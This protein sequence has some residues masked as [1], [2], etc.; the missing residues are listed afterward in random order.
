[1]G[2]PILVIAGAG[3]GKTRTLVHR[4]AFLVEQGVP[5]SQILLLTFTRKASAEMLSRARQLHP[6]C[7]AVEGGTFHSL[8]HRLLRQFGRRLE[9]P[10]NFTVIDRVDS[11]QVIRGVVEEL[12]LKDKGDKHFP[13]PRALADIISRSRNLELS[14]EE[15]IE[16]YAPQHEP[17]SAQVMGIAK[18]FKESK[19]RQ[20]L[21]DY[22]DLLFMGEELLQG[23]VEVRRELSRR[24]RHLLVDEYQD[25]NAVQARLVALLAS[26]HKNVMVVGDDAQS[27]YA[28]R[29]ARLQNILEF[30]HKFPG[31]RLVKLERN[32]RSS[33]PILDL[34]NRIIAQARERFDK[35][36]YTEQSGGL[37]PRLLRLRDERAQSR[38]VLKGI[39][40]L[41]AQGAAPE[42]IA[43][44]FRAGN[45][46]ADLE[47]E[48]TAEGLAH[49]KVGGL[50]FL[51]ASHIKDVLSHLRVIANPQDFLSW[52]R[53]LMLLPGLGPKKAQQIMAQL[54]LESPPPGYAVGLKYLPQVAQVPELT[55]LA[56]LLEHL[57]QP[58]LSPL[59]ATEAVLEYFEPICRQNYEDY[60]RRLRDLEELPGLA[61]NY[62]NLEELMAEVVLEPPANRS[63]E[64]GAG[65]LTLST[66]H[67]AK[68]LEWDHVFVL[69]LSEGR[70]PAGPTL[71]DPQALEEERRLLYVACTRA[72]Q[73]LTLLAPREY[74]SRGQGLTPVQLCRFLED[75]EPG[76]L[77]TPRLG[78]VFDVAPPA[79]APA[80]P[81]SRGSQH[82]N[83]P[84]AVGSLV[85]HASFGQGK[86][87]GYKGD[88][89]ILV[90]FGRFGLKIL[91]LEYAKLEAL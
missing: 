60:P 8:C 57:S 21:V 22:D 38:E 75:L 14:L 83:R 70:L 81:G 58:G 71:H 76:L 25:T 16:A 45:D 77:D 65:R 33:Q 47:L 56:L 51:E 37:K 74:Y 80:S 64:Q 34:T 1:V 62:D 61:R 2:G 20:A 88:N 3:T 63:E 82:Q 7:A 48:L 53:I 72:R 55:E 30:P 11:E 19:R 40:D 54:V 86:V 42:R 18:G 79:A 27:I 29:G 12:K 39:K 5:P 84:H 17:Y 32:Y 91:L 6:S 46:S 10:P 66:I 59:E 52:Q 9:L 28:F 23:H 26:E 90:H 49:V 36:L 15:A 89:K 44:L 68:G 67:S 85:S 69:W 87:M 4:V 31:T 13:K 78:P 50:R 35:Q 41:L 73:S 24:W 43:V